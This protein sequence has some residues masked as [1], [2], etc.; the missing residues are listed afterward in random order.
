MP[1]AERTVLLPIPPIPEEN[2]LPVDELIPDMDAL[3]VDTLRAT[4]MGAVAVQGVL[5]P[6]DF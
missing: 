3:E 1:D 5:G 4:T 6:I 2:L